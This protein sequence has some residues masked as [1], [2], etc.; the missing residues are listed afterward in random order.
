[1]AAGSG[2]NCGAIQED[3]GAAA[4]QFAFIATRYFHH[5]SLSYEE[6]KKILSGVA[7]KN[8]HNGM[9][10]P[11]A[12]LRREI[13]VEQAMNAPAVTWLL[14]LFDSCGVSD[15]SAAAIV[16]TPEI[17]KGLKKDHILVKAMGLSYGAFQ[18][19]QQGSYDFVHIEENVT[20]A[21]M[22]YKEAGIKSP[23]QE[24][25]L[26]EVHDCFS[27]TEVV[28][29]EDLGFCARG[30]YREEQEAGM[31][32]LTGDLHVNTD[33]GLKW[34]GHHIGATGL[35]I[36]YEV[37][38]QLQGKAGPRQLKKA[39]IDLTHNLGENSGGRMTSAVAIFGRA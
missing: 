19:V 5:H 34:F 17:A 4:V 20:A 33:G 7:V 11:K 39:D 12:D 23:R 2:A 15:G 21:Q 32:E 22:A 3:R 37:C 25:D 29:C 28:T 10:T 38:R 6:R 9:L 35:R 24:I 16:T 26:T 14:G 13:T 31:F 1:M 36:D 18:G 8:Q 30:K 27:I